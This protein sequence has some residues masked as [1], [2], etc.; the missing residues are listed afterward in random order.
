MFTTKDFQKY[1]EEIC[2]IARVLSREKQKDYSIPQD[3]LRN[4][5][6]AASITH[7]SLEKIIM[8]RLSEKVVRLGQILDNGYSVEKGEGIEASCIELIN[9]CVLLSAANEERQD[10]EYRGE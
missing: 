6:K 3:A 8:G 9:M 2:D 10:K 4:Y 5:R 1:H 7:T